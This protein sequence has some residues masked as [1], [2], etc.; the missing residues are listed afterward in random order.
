MRQQGC[1][2]CAEQQPRLPNKA[3][4][5]TCFRARASLPRAPPAVTSLLF[6]R[7]LRA[8]HIFAQIPTHIYTGT[9]PP[10][11]T[12]IHTHAHRLIH[13]GAYVCMRCLGRAAMARFHTQLR[14][15]KPAPQAHHFPPQ[16]A[17]LAAHLYCGTAKPRACCGVG[18]LPAPPAASSAEGGADS[19]VSSAH[20]GPAMR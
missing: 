8:V 3:P 19:S 14:L 7:S 20:R 11:H 12:H 2:Q 10:P 1:G 18:A 9:S 6:C 15:N 17:P 5:S 13:E 16:A 4:H